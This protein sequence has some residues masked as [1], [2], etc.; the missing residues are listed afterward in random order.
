VPSFPWLKQIVAKLPD[1][2]ANSNVVNVSVKTGLFVSNQ[3][4]VKVKP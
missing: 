1:E 4:T 2:I 3:V